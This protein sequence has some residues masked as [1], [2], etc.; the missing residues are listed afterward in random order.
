MTTLRLAH[1]LP[2]VLTVL[3]LGA[4]SARA[5]E[6][7]RSL[8]IRLFELNEPSVVTIGAHGG[9]VQVFAGDFTDP[10][11]AFR[12]GEF[13]IVSISNDQ[14]YVKVGGRGLYARS[15]RL[16]PVTGAACEVAVSE[17][18]IRSKAFRYPGVLSIG[19]DPA[20]PARLRLINTVGIED[21]VG[22]VVAREYGFDDLEGAKA[23]AVVIRT[24]ALGTKG[25]FGAEYDHVDHTGSQMYQGTEGVTPVIRNAVLQTRGEV[26]TY[27]NQLIQAVYFSSSGGHTADNDA[28]WQSGALPYLRGKPDPYDTAS[29][30]GEWRSEVSRPRLLAALSATYGFVV[31]G[32]HLGDRGPDDRVQTIDLLRPDDS[33]YTIRANDFRMLVLREFGSNAMRSTIF[34]ARRTGDTYVFEGRGN[35]HGV[36]LSQWGAHALALQGKT[37]REIIDFYYTGVALTQIEKLA[38]TPEKPPAHVVSKAD[39]PARPRARGRIGW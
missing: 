12:A 5:N 14:L 1:A 13:A 37:Y 19:L 20:H 25:K 21:Y 9:T 31:A 29:P 10:V 24:Y 18:R 35:G 34:T 39:E 16:V 23:M 7:D 22:A 4:P 38:T 32:F 36:G 8:R 33:R 11:A 30:Y 27:R 15:L 26:L 2:L 3:L 28:V 17:G 6:A